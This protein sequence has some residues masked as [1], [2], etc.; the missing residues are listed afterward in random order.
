MKAEMPGVWDKLDASL[1][2]LP[3]ELGETPKAILAISGH[4]EERDF[5]VMS[6]AQPPMIYD[7]SGFPEPT[8]H[9]KYPAPGAPE[10]AFR[11]Q[12]LLEKAGFKTA[13]DER[14]GFDHGVFVPFAVAYPKADV[15]ILQLSIR[16]D[17]N[18]DAHLKAG[19]ALAPLR[20]EGV[21]IA[22]SGLSYHNL[23]EFGPRGAVASRGFDEWLGETLCQLSG[24]ERSEELAR[25][26]SAPFARQAHPQEDHLIPLMVAVGAAE[27]EQGTRVYHED[28]LMGGISA[29][30]F[31][32]G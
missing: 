3:R 27:Q 7:Y 1:Q 25:W 23:R 11:V 20:D 24:R 17:Y 22:G 4:W 15:P 19:R 14:R 31:R 5:T 6:S 28:S 13:S 2:N 9:I 10:V 30:G 18:V 32:F 26:E 8:Y 21:L 16:A 29:S 12:Q